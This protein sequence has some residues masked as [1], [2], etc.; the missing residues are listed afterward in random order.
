LRMLEITNFLEFFEDHR[1]TSHDKLKEFNV[2][3]KQG[4]FDKQQQEI[5]GLYTIF[6]FQKKS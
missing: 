1:K 2:L 4:K 3:N 6:C 5:I